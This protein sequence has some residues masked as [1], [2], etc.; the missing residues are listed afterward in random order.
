MT[1]A[2]WDT[3]A[4]VP[5]CVQQQPTA[6]VREILEQYEI[7]VWW[8][9]SVEMRSAFE[10]LL[11]MGQLTQAEHVAAGM[12]LEKLRRGWR[13]L[14]PTEALRAQAETFLMSY[15][16]K[17]A[18]LY[19]LPPRGHGV[20]GMCNAARLSQETH[21]FLMP[22][23]RWDSKLFCRRTRNNPRRLWVVMGGYGCVCGSST[24]TLKVQRQEQRRCFA[25][26]ERLTRHPR[27]VSR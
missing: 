3:S 9:T 13:E 16:L 11:R 22:H 2:F 12:R 19:S 21:S 24:C 5:L 6:A 4:L 20:R 27:R 17:A 25:S 7:A 8:A 23:D 10:R 14:Q 1:P 15:P 26:E 18:E